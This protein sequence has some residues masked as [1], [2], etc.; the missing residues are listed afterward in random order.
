MVNVDRLFQ[1]YG[2]VE[3]GTLNESEFI[4]MVC[5][6]FG[7]GDEKRLHDLFKLLSND[8]YFRWDI[9]DKV[10]TLQSKLDTYTVKY[11]TCWIW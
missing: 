4:A 7:E 11:F 6:S 3:E 8:G 1:K 2:T 9:N 5:D 10:A